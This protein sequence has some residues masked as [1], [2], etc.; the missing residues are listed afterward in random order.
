M[1]SFI[2]DIADENNIPRDQV[3]LI[4]C[5]I[6]SLLLSTAFRY[7]TS[8]TL[9]KIYSLICGPLI[10]YALYGFRILDIAITNLFLIITVYTLPR[11][12]VGIVNNIFIA[13]HLG[14]I[15]YERMMIF[16]GEWNLEI[17]FVYMMTLPRWS[18]FSF[19]YSDA[20]LKDK[21]KVDKEYLIE[22]FNMLNF[23]SYIYFIPSCITGP[24]IEYK[25][26]IDFVYLKG[27]YSHIKHSNFTVVKKLILALFFIVV[28]SLFKEYFHINM[29]FNQYENLITNNSSPSIT[30]YIYLFGLYL[31]TYYNR[32]KYY[33]GFLL[34]DASCDITGI[35]YE[36]NSN[37]A[38]DKFTR[39]QSCRPLK[40]ETTLMLKEYFRHWNLSVHKWLKRYV[41]KRIIPFVGKMQAE[42]ITFIISGLWHGFYLSY[43]LLFASIIIGSYLQD[44]VMSIRKGFDLWKNN[45]AIFGLKY[46]LRVI[47]E[48]V[49]FCLYM[50]AYNYSLLSLDHLRL[51]D[52]I[53]V[54][55]KLKFVPIYSAAVLT[56]IL[57]AIKRCFKNL[58]KQ[59]HEDNKNKLK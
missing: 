56:I 27:N 19:N 9:R 46:T 20:A 5:Y 40:C 36:S 53:E 29:F 33:V 38:N 8:P 45:K 2:Y 14:Y 41:F 47:F 44:I 7:I 15:H 51:K 13:A 10:Q 4:L 57:L 24:F 52:L 12:Y 39:V 23:L 35:S 37:D 48:I 30:T 25:D 21:S 28:F 3:L 26:Y 17:S 43:H 18:S 31:I 50:T 22:D 49:Y 6:I 59:Y 58:L 1:I 55:Y 32:I 16:Y 34:A 54:T 11:K 42:I